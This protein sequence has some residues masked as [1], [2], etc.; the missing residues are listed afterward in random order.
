MM[1][2]IVS[3]SVVVLIFLVIILSMYLDY[4]GRGGR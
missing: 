4:V 3:V 2:V 1:A